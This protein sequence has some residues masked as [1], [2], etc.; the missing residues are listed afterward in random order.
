MMSEPERNY[1]RQEAGAAATAALANGVDIRT[2]LESRFGE[3]RRHHPD[4]EDRLLALWDELTSRP[5]V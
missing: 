5:Q 3:A 1:F 4:E 2:A